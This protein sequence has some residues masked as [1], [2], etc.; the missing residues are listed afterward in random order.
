MHSRPVEIYSSPRWKISPHQNPIFLRYA[1]QYIPWRII[2]AC[3][4]HMNVPWFVR[5]IFD[6][7][8]SLIV[9]AYS[10][11]FEH[12]VH[13][14]QSLLQ[15][16]FPQARRSWGNSNRKTI[17]Y[18]QE[19]CCWSCVACREDAYVYNDTCKKCNP[20]Y[21][22]NSTMTGCVK[23]TAEVIPWTSPWAHLSMSL[24]FRKLPRGSLRG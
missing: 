13:D 16:V 2:W 7:R 3:K 24:P 20:G 19:A 14:N 21:A 9:R 15:R 23:L 18:V 5:L 8:L 22:P 1:R 6:S 10:L 4:G 11:I 17:S 12:N